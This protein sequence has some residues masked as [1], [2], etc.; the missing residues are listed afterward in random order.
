M[1]RSSARVLGA[2]RPSPTRSP[3]GL[4]RWREIKIR[5]RNNWAVSSRC[6]NGPQGNRRPVCCQWAQSMANHRASTFC[7]GR[8]RRNGRRARVG[9]IASRSTQYLPGAIGHRAAVSEHREPFAGGA[10]DAAGPNSSATHPASVRTAIAGIKQMLYGNFY[11]KRPTPV[12]LPERWRSEH[13]ATRNG[14]PEQVARLR[15][16]RYY[17]HVA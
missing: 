4:E 8:A 9:E 3:A 12:D 5:F 14:W 2:Q 11:C 13:N 1:R 7:D 16:W 15:R 6:D 17:R 10:G